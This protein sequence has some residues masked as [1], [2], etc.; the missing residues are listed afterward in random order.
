MAYLRE[1]DIEP[2]ITASTGIAATHIGGMTIHSWSGTGIKTKLDKYDL[3][4]IASTEYIAKRVLRAQV[5][6]IDEVSMLL[7]ETLSMIDAVCREIK[8][9]P[10]PFG[11]LQIILV[12]DFFQLPPIVKN[13]IKENN[14]QSMLLEE[15]STRFAYDSPAWKRANPIVCYLTEQ[16]RQ[17]DDNF[18][19]ILSAIRTDT[20]G[21]NHLFH[22]ETRKIKHSAAPESAPKLFRIM[23]MW[24]AS[25]KRY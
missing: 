2:A 6:I 14:A 9:S 1:R 13:E 10:D 25:T 21:E 5:L 12:G 16:Y 15:S 17:D 22:I 20:F 4:K 19:S 8:R 23:R 18:L 24:T 3:D 11:G 7:S